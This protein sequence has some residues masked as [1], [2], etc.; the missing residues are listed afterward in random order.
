MWKLKEHGTTKAILKKNKVGELT[1]FNS[2][3]YYKEVLIKTVT[4]G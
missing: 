1:V 4:W 2:K 3:T